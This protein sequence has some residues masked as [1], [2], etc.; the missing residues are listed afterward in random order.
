[1]VRDELHRLVDDVLGEDARSALIAYRNL[2]EQQLPWLEQ[3]VVAQARLDGLNWAQIGRLLGRSRQSVRD[4]FASLVPGIAPGP[5]E[6]PFER[7]LRK[8]N[9][10]FE[11]LMRRINGG[12]DDDEPVAW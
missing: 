7:M 9:E 6:T 1:M 10:G 12:P 5:I 2:A 4:R 3:R 11:Q 8:Q